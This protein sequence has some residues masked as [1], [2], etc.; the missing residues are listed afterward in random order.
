MSSQLNNILHLEDH[1]EFVAAIR[2]RN[3]AA[4]LIAG[5]QVRWGATVIL[6]AI[7]SEI[8]HT[9]VKVLAA[10]AMMSNLKT[11]FAT[12][13]LHELAAHVGRSEEHVSRSIKVLCDRG[14]LFTYRKQK[15]AGERACV[16]YEIGTRE[17]VFIVSWVR[18]QRTQYDI[19]TGDLNMDVRVSPEPT[20]TNIPGS[21]PPDPAKNVQ[22]SPD[23]AKNVRVT[24]FPGWGNFAGSAEPH[25]DKNTRVTRSD[26]AKNVQVRG[27]EKTPSSSTEESKKMK[28]VIGASL[29]SPGVELPTA[30]REAVQAGTSKVAAASL[31]D[32]IEAALARGVKPF[33]IEMS[34][35]KSATAAVTQ[36]GG[37][38]PTP[39]EVLTKAARYVENSDGEKL[40]D[41]PLARNPRARNL[42]T[43]F[44]VPDLNAMGK[45][46]VLDADVFF[47]D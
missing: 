15:A 19:E 11:G 10:I 30:I 1:D 45:I 44:D 25:P 14:Y 9:A 21:A 18:F 32:A 20:L 6:A 24:N 12:P 37:K 27:G 28:M 5:R 17:D 43:S 38:D 39:S 42:D 31:M 29:L 16:H 22:V 36:R 26:P 8:S 34:L 47:A 33:Q 13:E 3:D 2:A 41:G 35:R 46:E 4:S 23:P 40:S 7:D